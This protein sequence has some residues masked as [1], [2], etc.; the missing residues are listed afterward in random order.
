MCAKKVCKTE[1]MKR[2][3]ISF[4]DQFGQIKCVHRK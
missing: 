2:I 4:V 3:V 1:E